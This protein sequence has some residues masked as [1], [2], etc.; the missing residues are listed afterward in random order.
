M[1]FREAGALWF[2]GE[3]RAF[4]DATVPTLRA[5][6][7][8]VEQLTPDE[9]HARW[10]QIATDDITGAVYEPEAGLLMAARGLRDRRAPARRARWHVRASA[11]SGPG[12]RDGDRLLDVEDDAGR[13]CAADDIRVRGRAVAAAAVP[14]CRR[15]ARSPSPSRTSSISA[16]AAGDE[17]WTDA[18]I[19]CWVDMAHP[20][21]G[22]PS[23]E[24]GG[25]KIAPDRFGPAWDPTD[26]RPARGPRR[27]AR[28]ARLRR[29]PASR[30]SPASPS[31]RPASASTR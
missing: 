9:V 12:G 4:A 16:P 22:L 23:A 14:G 3:D 17:R 5:L 13:R 1:L 29:A 19:P 8:Q 6:D 18:A 2:T 11:P 27:G 21:Y 30:A 24:G 15:R 31:S 25:F 26:G 10:P 20:F 7:I 28:G